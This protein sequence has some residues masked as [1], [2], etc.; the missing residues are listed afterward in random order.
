MA[1]PTG[2]RGSWFALWRGERLPCL[3]KCW[4][5]AESGRLRYCDP[6][7]SD[8]WEWPELIASIREKGRVI[9]TDDELDARGFPKKRK[10]YIAVFR[11]D[12]VVVRA[13]ELHLDLVDREEFK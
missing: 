1:G 6:E 3:H 13:A 8:E 12:N 11:V 10:G 9:L 4:T 7:V 2:S 5:K